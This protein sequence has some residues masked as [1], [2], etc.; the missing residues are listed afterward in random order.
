VL[1]LIFLPRNIT[2]ILERI[3]ER[4]SVALSLPLHHPLELFYYWYSSFDLPVFAIAPY[5]GT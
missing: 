4:L 5:P 1:H 3:A 2:T